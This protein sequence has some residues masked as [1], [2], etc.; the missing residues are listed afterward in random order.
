M[1][2]LNDDIISKILD[3][4]LS[5]IDKEIDLLIFNLNI[6]YYIINT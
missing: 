2:I 5:D 1:I 4:R 6:I 3:Y